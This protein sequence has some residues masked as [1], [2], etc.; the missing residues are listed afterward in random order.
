MTNIE[1][2]KAMIEAFTR[3]DFPAILDHLAQ[4]V[5][6]DYDSVSDVPWYRPRR[7]K[8]EVAGFFEAIAET[9]I[10]Q[11]EPKLYLGEGDLVVVVIDSDYRV[12]STGRRVV[13]RDC[14]LLLRFDAEGR[15]VRF[16]HR[17][18]LFPGWLAYH[19]KPAPLPQRL[20]E[21]ALSA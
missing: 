11:W 20:P 10:T 18:D 3:G 7:G 8:A 6:W 13:C 21:A 19:D 17:T 15:V 14:L 1:T 12:K 2:T 4:D 9:E 5:E 16:N